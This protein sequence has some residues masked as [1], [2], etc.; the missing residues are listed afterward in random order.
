MKVAMEELLGLESELNDSMKNITAKLDTIKQKT[1]NISKLASFQGKAASTAKQYFQTVHGQSVE[2]LKAVAQQLQKNFSKIISEFQHTVDQ[3]NNAII[4]EDYLHDLNK[5]VQTIKNGVLDTH[6]EGEQIIRNVSDI[7]SLNV[8]TIS[9][10]T[11]SVHDSQKHVTEVN[12]KLH[13]FDQRALQIV[14]DTKHEVEKVMKKIGEHAANS[15]VGS[16][17]VAKF[18][19]DDLGNK[20]QNDSS[21]LAAVLVTMAIGSK[22]FVKVLKNINKANTLSTVMA[23]AYVYYKLKD[24]EARINFRKKGIHAFTK[25]QYR[26]FNNYLSSTLYKIKTKE[27]YRHLDQYKSKAF[28][29]DNLPKLLENLEVYGKERGKL[30][31]MREFEELYGLDKYRE[32]KKLSHSKKALKMATTFGDELVGKKYITTKKA[33]KSLPNWKDPKVAYKNAVENFKESTKGMNSLGKSMKVVGKGL[34]PLGMGIIAADNY[35]TYK[36]D[37][38]KVVV[39]TAVDGVYS[40]GATAIG[41]AVGSAFFPPIGTVVGAGVGMLVSAG[42]NMK[43]GNPPKSLTERTKDFVNKKVDSVSKTC[44]KIGSKISSWFK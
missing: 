23:Q 40:A 16:S 24:K 25:E 3:S 36:G 28:T 21:H 29:K 26:T 15:V 14:Q 35:N 41:A 1:N 30:A 33:I 11:N 5:E 37:T 32:F 13:D 19:P 31:M 18:N 8:P 38:Q 12:K 2:D 27:F 34:G 10:F 4:T 42:L 6:H 22:S 20:E 7:V 17:D 39:G 9:P 43:G 44:K